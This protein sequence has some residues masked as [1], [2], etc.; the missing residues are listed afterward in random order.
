MSGREQRITK[1]RLVDGKV[2]IEQAD[3][4]LREAKGRTDWGRVDALTDAE[5]ERLAKQ[6]GE[7]AFFPEDQEPT[8]VSRPL[9]PA[10]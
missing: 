8:R 3:G 2:M 9:A 6:D 4:T 1:A 5:I 7:D 10:K